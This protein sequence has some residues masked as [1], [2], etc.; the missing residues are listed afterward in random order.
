M[1]L[2]AIIY[3]S[4][5]VKTNSVIRKLMGYTYRHMSDGTHIYRKVIS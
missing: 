5:F 4:S 2:G 1:S 3:T